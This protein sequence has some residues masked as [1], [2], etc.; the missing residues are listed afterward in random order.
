MRVAKTVCEEFPLPVNAELPGH[1][2]LP[3]LDRNLHSEFA[4]KCHNGVQVIWH[5]QAQPTVP[6]H[7]LVIVFNRFEDRVASGNP[8]QLVAA[9]RNTFDRDEEPT[10]VRNPFRN[11]MRKLFANGQVHAMTK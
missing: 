8:A 3:I 6:N 10:A 7:L 9:G 1:I 4:W 5:E 11:R 2:P